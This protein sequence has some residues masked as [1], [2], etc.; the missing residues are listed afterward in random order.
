MEHPSSPNEARSVDVQ[1]NGE[2][3][4]PTIYVFRTH[5]DNKATEAS[6]AYLLE[7][8]E[9]FVHFNQGKWRQFVDKLPSIFQ[10]AEF[11]FPICC[12]ILKSRMHCSQIIYKESNGDLMSADFSQEF[13]E[14]E[15]VWGHS[16]TVLYKE[17][18]YRGNTIEV[19]FL[20]CNKDV[21]LCPLDAG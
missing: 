14:V 6:G 20:A 5:S 4:M 11:N 3:D 1:L 17:D 19:E 7:C 13:I 9:V 16:R 21:K 18:R 8:V 12:D 2:H 15:T 10:I